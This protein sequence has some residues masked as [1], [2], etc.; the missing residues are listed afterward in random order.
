MFKSGRANVEA[1]SRRLYNVDPPVQSQASLFGIRGAA[2][3]GTGTG[4]CPSISLFLLSV[5][6]HSSVIDAILS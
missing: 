2:H 3:S 6:F 4:F 5:P 1:V